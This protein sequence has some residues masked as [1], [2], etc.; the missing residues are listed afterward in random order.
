MKFF[1]SLKTA[2]R[3]VKHAKMRSFLTMLGIIIG[4]ASVIVLMSIGQ[5]VQEYILDQVNSLGSNLIYIIPGGSTG[6]R[7][8]VPAAA[9]GVVIKTL[10]ERDVD[11]LRREPGIVSVAAIVR[12]QT[13]A[14]YE[15]NDSSITWQGTSPELFAIN[16]LTLSQGAAFT[17]ADADAY[18]HVAV[19]GSALAKTLFGE[20]SPLDK[21]IRLKDMSF[22][23]VG[24]LEPKGVG[25]GGIDQDTMVLVPLTVGQKQLLGISYYQFIVIQAADTY[26]SEFIR[27]RA[28]SILRQNHS[29][30]DPARDD[31]TIRTQEDAIT[32][33]SSITS[34]LTIFLTAIAAISLVVGGIGIM[35][36]MLVS[37]IERT[38]EIGLRK[39]VGATNRDIVQQFLGEAII[40]TFA[41]GVGGILLGSVIT[42]GI[43]FALTQFL[44]TG[45]VFALPLSA[46]FL[47]VGVSVFTGLVFGIYPAR[48]ASLKSPIEAL[49]Y[50]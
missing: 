42:I 39:A 25:P 31:F 30:T 13:R 5:S 16:K 38:R 47:A 37:V 4:I 1:D 15:N 48:Q 11:A 32:T 43:Y 46:I 36:I 41:G 17:S 49:R 40:L 24:V 12:G 28:V 6:S 18:N 3:G 14:I 27:A 20:R 2:T 9:Q 19:I 44:T 23:V 10:V 34:V 50:E 21:S 33:L 29:I 22:R 45:W 7:F 26:D 8:S 35:N